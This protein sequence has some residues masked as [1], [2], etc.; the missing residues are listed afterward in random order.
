[1]KNIK[2]KSQGNFGL[3]DEQETYQKLSEIGN[4]LEKISSVIDF[5]MFRNTLEDGI[6]GFIA[7]I[8]R[9]YV[10]YGLMTADE[11]NPKY[12]EDPT[13]S[14]KVNKYIEKIRNS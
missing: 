2:Y 11:M 3:F 14:S 7:N 5:E 1:M 13:W 9:N 8:K 6:Y 4:P 10:D 12:A